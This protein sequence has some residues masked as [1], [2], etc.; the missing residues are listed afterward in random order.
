[1]WRERGKKGEQKE[2]KEEVS[3]YD[4]SKGL[5]FNGFLFFSFLSHNKF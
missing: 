1:V 4:K 2:K 5:F 3:P